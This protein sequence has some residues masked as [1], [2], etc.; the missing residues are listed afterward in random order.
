MYA[1]ISRLLL[2]PPVE[3]ALRLILGGILIFA[4]SIKILDM[5]AMADSILNYRMLPEASVNLAAMILPTLEILIGACLISGLLFHGALLAATGV[6]ALFWLAVAWAASQGYDIE[7]GCFG[8][9]ASMK[10]GL[11]ALLR[12][13]LFLAGLAPLWFIT[14]PAWR[15]DALL[16]SSP[17]KTSLPD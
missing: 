1:P 8:T 17:A 9:A 15:L 16:F 3:L 4:G 12:N 13:T 5:P 11:M 6:Y 2:S 10:V 7:C 14:Q